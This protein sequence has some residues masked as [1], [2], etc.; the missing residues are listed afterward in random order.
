MVVGVVRPVVTRVWAPAGLSETHRQHR[1]VL[2]ARLNLN[3]PPTD[4]KAPPGRGF[5]VRGRQAGCGLLRCGLRIAQPDMQFA[6]LLL[7][8]Q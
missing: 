6:Q 3:Q 5:I 7:V 1:S 2:P 4:E 8:D